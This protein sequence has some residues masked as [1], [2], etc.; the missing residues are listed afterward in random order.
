V[1]W[2]V[3]L[4]SRGNDSF[5]DMLWFDDPLMIQ[6]T[7]FFSSSCFHFRS[8]CLFS[9]I[10]RPFSTSIGRWLFF[11]APGPST[12][13]GVLLLGRPPLI[14]DATPLFPTSPTVLSFSQVLRS[15]PIAGAFCYTFFCTLAHKIFFPPGPFALFMLCLRGGLLFPLTLYR[16]VVNT[17]P[18]LVVFE[19]LGCFP[20]FFFF[21]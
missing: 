10:N 17:L 18:S 16:W 8:S 9:Q 7:I 19:S 5:F 3:S 21:W 15:L 11:F 6:R 1:R 4:W 14:S 2:T 13:Q 20:L 12:Y